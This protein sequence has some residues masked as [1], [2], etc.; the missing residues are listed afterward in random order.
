MRAEAVTAAST[1]DEL[2]SISSTVGAATL[3]NSVILKDRQAWLDKHRI[4]PHQVTPAQLQIMLAKGA[5]VVAPWIIL[6][7]SVLK[8]FA[9]F[10]GGEYHGWLGVPAIQIERSSA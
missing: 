7:R 8:L 2:P 4:M 6:A 9:C 5:R 10:E 1:M 3:Q